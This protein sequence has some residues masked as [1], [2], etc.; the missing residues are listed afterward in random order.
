MIFY[1]DLP[2]S[3]ASTFLQEIDLTQVD[4]IT[5]HNWILV[6]TNDCLTSTGKQWF[7]D[8]KIFTYDRS[9][10]FK[11]TS[12]LEHSLH[13]DSNILSAGFNFVLSGHGE[14]QWAGDIEADVIVSNKIEKGHHFSF[15]R[16]EN[17][18]KLTVID[19]WRGNAGLV[20]I[21]QPHRIVTYA[22]PRYCLSIR[23]VPFSSEFKFDDLV[24]LF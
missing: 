22:E 2:D 5:E 14:M 19:K 12:N 10:L 9:L 7:K 6:N 17:I 8:H 23:P 21:N 4:H 20:R 1:K 18:Q 3:I 16:Y 15:T 11:A 24:K 13:T